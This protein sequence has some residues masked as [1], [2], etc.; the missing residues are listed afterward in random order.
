MYKNWSLFRYDI[1]LVRNLDFENNENGVIRSLKRILEEKEI[2]KIL[3]G[4]NADMLSLAKAEIFVRNLHDTAIMEK[5][6]DFQKTGKC[7]IQRDQISFKTLCQLYGFEVE[8]KGGMKQTMKHGGNFAKNMK[9][10]SDQI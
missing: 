5:I 6:I 1:F 4:C 7:L 2:V 3:H 10:H 8:M 9:V